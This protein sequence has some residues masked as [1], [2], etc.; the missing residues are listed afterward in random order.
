[1]SE[2]NDLNKEIREKLFSMQ[3]IK[4]KE[5]HSGLSPN[6]DG[7]IG[8]RVPI[9]KEYAKEIAKGDWRKYLN[10]AQDEYYEERLLQGLVIGY[11]KADAEEIIDYLTKFVPKINSWGVC[12]STI[13]NLKIIKKNKEMFWDFINKYLKSKEEYELRFAIVTMLDYY[14]D[15]IYIDKVIKELDKIK[16]EG[17]YVKMAVAWA[18]SL[19]YIKFPEKTMQYFKNCNLDDWTY[20]KAIQKTVESYRVTDEDK[21]ILR[22]MR[23]K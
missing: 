16:H 11:V 17:Y 14:V 12:D 15:E 6:I 22:N 7:I 13:M 10:G 3:D 21:E 9:L 2:L 19:C 23:R 18:L 20:N 4:Y 8:I 1:M 5:F